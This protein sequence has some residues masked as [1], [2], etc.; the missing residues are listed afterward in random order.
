MNVQPQQVPHPKQVAHDL[1]ADLRES[2]HGT[3]SIGIW[4]AGMVLQ[5][6]ERGDDN[7]TVYQARQMMECI[8]TFLKTHGELVSLNERGREQ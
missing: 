3:L 1:K 6:L 8:R 5:Y 7:G 2:M 4:H